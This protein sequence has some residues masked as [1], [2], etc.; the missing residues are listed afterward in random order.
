MSKLLQILK[1]L[2]LIPFVFNTTF[3]QQKLD[4][5]QPL[6]IDGDIA[7]EMVSGIDRFLLKQ[8]AE[9]KQTRFERWEKAYQS[10]QGEKW[11]D[12][13]RAKLASIL[14]L[15]EK[16]IAFNAFELIASTKQSSTVFKDDEVTIHH[17]RWPVVAD[18]T[19]TGFL[20][21]PKSKV[22]ANLIA[23]PDATQTPG[24]IAGFGEQKKGTPT[25]GSA[26]ALARA[27]FRVVVPLTVSRRM[28]KRMNGATLTDREFVYRSSF[29][30]G[31]HLIGY[32][33]QSIL[34]IVDHLKNQNELTGRRSLRLGRWRNAFALR[35]SDRQA[36]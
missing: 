1:T 3:S 9:S 28:Q 20:I 6:S 22:K 4:G 19:A 24:D 14:G 10:G 30:L 33:L 25:F 23:I 18:I 8:L 2:C 15:R 31:R 16:R 7:S 34:A 12:S 5:T 17:V 27:G 32:E 21:S 29:V 36:N 26:T 11:F 13:Q 35:G